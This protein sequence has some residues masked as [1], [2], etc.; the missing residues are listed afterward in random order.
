[1][2][3]IANDKFVNGFAVIGMKTQSLVFLEITNVIGH[4]FQPLVEMQASALISGAQFGYRHG[5]IVVVR[6]ADQLFQQLRIGWLQNLVGHTFVDFGNQIILNGVHIPC[7]SI[8][9][10]NSFED[11][12]P[13]NTENEE[14]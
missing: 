7:F 12:R 9:S 8:A 3:V 14:A 5:L 10:G 1:M 6:L 2:I 11:N 4:A 13:A